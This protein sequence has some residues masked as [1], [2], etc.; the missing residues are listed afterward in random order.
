MMAARQQLIGRLRSHTFHEQLV[1]GLVHAVGL[2]AGFAGAS[3]LVFFTLTYHPESL[4]VV[5]VYCGGLL[6]MLGASAMYNL[7]Y[8]SRHRDVLRNLDHS[9]IFLMMAGTYTPFTLTFLPDAF[10]LATT[11]LIW[12]LSLAGIGLRFF[13]PIAFARYNVVLYL[14]LGWIAVLI[15]GPLLTTTFT[16]F[17]GFSLLLGGALYTIGVTFHIW[18]KLPFQNA[19]WH[20][21][22][23]AAAFCHYLAVLEGVA[24]RG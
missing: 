6:S 10:G 15:V 17:T 7:A 14:A 1:D 5:C 13:A 2:S 4:A 11:G 20:M 16:L 9:A 8:A 23:L 18:E 24:L 21:F 19:I 12:I 22:V 3:A